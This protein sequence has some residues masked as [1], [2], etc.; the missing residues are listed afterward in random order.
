MSEV[1]GLGAVRLAYRVTGPADGPP[2]VLLRAL[3]SDA[4][5]WFN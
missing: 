1:A 5:T 3:G 4:A 2:V